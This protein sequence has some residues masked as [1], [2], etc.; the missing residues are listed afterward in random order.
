M[1]ISKNKKVIL[2]TPESQIEYSKVL[3]SYKDLLFFLAWRDILIRFKQTFLGF[4]WVAIK[5]ILT[6]LIM[7][8]VFSKIAMMPSGAP[9]PVLI[10]TALLPWQFFA[11]GVN[12]SSNSLIGNASLISKIYFP[13]IILPISAVAP[14]FIDFFVSL[15]IL[16][17]LMLWYEQD[18]T[19][20]FLVLPLAFML[21]FILTVSLGILL[22]ALNIKFR[23]FRYIIPIFIQF[24]LYLSPVGF[25]TNI[26]PDHWIVFYS[27]NPMVGII[28]LFRWIILGEANKNFCL[29]IIISLIVTT[30]ILIVA[31][32]Y[33]KKTEKYFSDLV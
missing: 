31:A 20:K 12:D 29:E 26:I 6:M 10:F 33:F 21:I 28:D 19:L 17:I 2:I 13:R 14:A 7:F 1:S 25:S 15:I 30:F 8:L 16:L 4:L 18:I 27:L 11:S 22:S 5:P 3:W 24:G 23:D 32:K 9:Y